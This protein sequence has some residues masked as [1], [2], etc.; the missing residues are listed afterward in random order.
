MKTLI[1]LSED[2]NRLEGFVKRKQNKQR[3]L[4]GKNY[5]ELDLGVFA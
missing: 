3:L 2:G 4:S 1:L 5:F